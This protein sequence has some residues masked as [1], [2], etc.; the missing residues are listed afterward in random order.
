MIN[1]SSP[2]KTFLF[3]RAANNCPRVKKCMFSGAE[4]DPFHPY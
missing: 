2:N 4:A 3:K 1:F